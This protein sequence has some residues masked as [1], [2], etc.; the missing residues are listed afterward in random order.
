M[1]RKASG[2]HGRVGGHHRHGAS[3]YHLRQTFGFLNMF[4]INHPEVMIG[5]AASRSMRKGT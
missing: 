2:D 5:N 3:A 1:G 4:P